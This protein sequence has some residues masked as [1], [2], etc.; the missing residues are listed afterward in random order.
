MGQRGDRAAI[1]DTRFHPQVQVVAE[2]AVLVDQLKLAPDVRGPVHRGHVDELLEA[3]L[4][5]IAQRLSQR[6]YGIRR[7]L[8]DRVAAYKA[9]ALECLARKF[10]HAA[11]DAR[12]VDGGG[13]RRGDHELA[14]P[15]Q[16]ALAPGIDVSDAED[17]DEH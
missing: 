1:A 5:V 17:A 4:G 13:R 15:V 2:R 11:D 9:T 14:A 6:G 7:D 8:N 16:G 12:R 3:Q 10:A